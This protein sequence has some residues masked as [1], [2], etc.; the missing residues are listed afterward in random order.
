MRLLGL[1]LTTVFMLGSASLGSASA[2]AQSEPVSMA[3]LNDKVRNACMGE[4]AIGPDAILR[5]DMDG[6]GKQDVLFNWAK[7]TCAAQISATGGGGFC[8]MH[9]C[10]ID[11]Y[12]STQYRPGGYPT[13]I[14]NHREIAPQIIPAGA[15]PILRTSYQGGNCTFA[16]VCEMAWRWDGRQF[17]STPI[18]REDTQAARSAQQPVRLSREGLAGNW[19]SAQD[20]CATDFRILF[21]ADG[22]YE[23]YEE[24]GSWRLLGNNIA[25]MVRETFVMG[26]ESS[27][28]LI[29]DPDPVVWTVK[30]LTRTTLTVQDAEGRQFSY[31]RCG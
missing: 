6:D 20:G 5:A 11:V 16:E 8:G 28:R 17:Q 23:S 31:R 30:A 15:Y 1:C 9:N 18:A 4:G 22:R 26:E 19:V 10:S 29:R 25:I 13:P 2:F 12:L 24:A 27:H 7:V 21:R 14:L 3:T